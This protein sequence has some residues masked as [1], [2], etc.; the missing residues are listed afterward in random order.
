MIAGTYHVTATNS[1]N[2]AEVATATV[3]VAAGPAFTVLHSF[4]GTTEGAIPWAPLIWGTDGYMYAPTIAGGNLSCGYISSYQG[5]GTLYRIDTQGNAEVLKSFQGTDGAYPSDALVQASN[6][7]MYGTTGFGGTDTTGCGVGTTPSGCGSLFTLALPNTFS[8]I[9]SFG[10]YSSTLGISPEVVLLNAS[11]GNWYGANVVGGGTNCG[12]T[13]GTVSQPACG[14]LFKFSATNTPIL[15]HAFTGADGAY[16]AGGLIQGTD[17]N[18]YGV[19]EGGGASNCSSYAKPGCG[20]VFRITTAGS[21]QTL[22]AFTQQDGATPAARLILGQ[23]GNLYGTTLFGGSSV[24]SG[25]AQWQGCGTVFRIDGSGNFKLIHAFEGPDGAY[26]A[27]LYQGADGY[28]YGTAEGGGDANCS[29]RYGPGCG[30]VFRMDPTGNVTVIHSFTGQSDG[31]WPESALIQ[32]GDGSL[33]GTAAY[34]GTYDDGVVFK[35][36]NLASLQL[37]A[38]ISPVRGPA[39]DDVTPILNKHPH[40]SLPILSEIKN[41]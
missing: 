24:C 7:T 38:A 4:N 34:G 33:F 14:T 1:A 37:G 30:V 20:T 28:F 23:D 22:H 25:G 40:V 26:P 41:K 9:F 31:A 32:G 19:T 10:P 3:T 17:G 8:S 16:P 11:D 18:L 36:S 21:L 15:L 12:G 13:L 39:S 6:G 2:A 35:I 29:G 5:C 27:R